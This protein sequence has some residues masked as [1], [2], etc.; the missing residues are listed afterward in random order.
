ME[1]SSLKYSAYCVSDLKACSRSDALEELLEF[2]PINVNS[3]KLIHGALEMRE[4]A[5]PT[6]IFPGISLPHC[7]SIL[8][9]NLTVVIGRSSVGVPWPEEPVKV[10]IMFISPVKPD[11]P[12]EHLAFISHVASRIKKSAEAILNASNSESL[13]SLLGMELILGGVDEP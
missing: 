2:I 4:Q 11:G 12:H 8:V 6:T 3:R 5:G 7:R 10:M 13:L 9:D 1:G